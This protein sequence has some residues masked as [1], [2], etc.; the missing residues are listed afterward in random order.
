MTESSFAAWLEGVSPGLEGKRF[1]VGSG[2]IRL[3]R[4]A[5]CSIPIIDPMVSREHA[6]IRFLAGG[7]VIVDLGSSHGTWVDGQQ[8]SEASL[9]PGAR[10]RLGSSEFVFH[11]PQEAIPT[12][13]VAGQPTVR[14]AS[15]IPA[16]PVSGPSASGPPGAALP[17]ALGSA[18]A[19][20]A[21]PSGSTPLPAK[22]RRGSRIVIG[23]GLAF[24]LAVCGCGALLAVSLATGFPT[25]L[26]ATVNQTLERLAGNPIS[27]E[28]LALALA[29]PTVDE[30]PE[31][32]ENLGRPDEF[33]ISFVQVEGGQVR[34]ESWRYYRLGTRV[35]FAD[36]VIVWTIDLELAP[37]GSLFPAWYDPTA[38][39]TGITMDEAT[40]L[41][42]A[43]SPA[44]FVPETIDL[45]EGGED[46]AGGIML[47]GDQITLGFEEGRLV[48]VE[49]LGVTTQESDG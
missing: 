33:D 5:S 12:A 23:C 49:T 28:D 31:I 11:M 6:E 30:R 9:R 24:I 41:V 32:L 36:G 18:R 35:D 20:G 46:L 19:P 22:K 37:A 42:T 2:G 25:G 13:M 1:D 38:F 43:A 34:L 3:G 48:Y 40:A 27:S 15:P 45:S 8:V 17:A 39:E 47:V 14:E 29:A 26:A 7:Y 4:S 10:I 21:A 44:G 16:R